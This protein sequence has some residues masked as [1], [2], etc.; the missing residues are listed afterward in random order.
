MSAQLKYSDRD[1]RENPDYERIALDY[2]D[3]YE[4]E[5]QYLIDCKMRVEMGKDLTVGMFRGILNCMRMDPRAPE[6]PAPLPPDD[7][8]EVVELRPRTPRRQK[9]IPYY[10]RPECPLFVAG[11][12]HVH[13]RWTAEMSDTYQHCTGLYHINRVTSFDL[14]ATVKAPFLVARGGKMIHK[15]EGEGYVRWYP[16]EHDWGWER[17]LHPKLSAKVQC[18]YP[19][20]IDQPIL[21]FTP[22]ASFQDDTPVPLCVRC[23]AEGE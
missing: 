22:E 1:V 20:W 11:L 6:L 19:R 3:G 2:L 17:H 18:M 4:G 13:K 16:N 9:F 12:H 23:F 8:G 5:F 7:M 14:P 15:T 21:L 10:K